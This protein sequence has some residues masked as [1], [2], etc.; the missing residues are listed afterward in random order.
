MNLTQPKAD[1]FV[2]DGLPIGEALA[3]TTHLG[4]GAHQDDLEFMSLHGILECYDRDDRWYSGVVVTNGGGSAR[5][6][7]FAEY[8]DEEMQ[9]VRVQEQC[10]A[11][12]LGRYGSQIQLMFSSAEVKDA[13]YPG[14][15]E[16]LRT[17]VELARPEVVYMHN[18]ADKHDTHVACCLR[19]IAA[20]R[21]LPADLRPA[22]V[23]GCEVWRDLDWLVDA[24]KQA[25][26]LE[27]PDELGPRLARLFESQIAGGKRYDLAVQGRQL[28]NATF[29]QSHEVDQHRALSFAMDLTPLVADPELDIIDFALDHLHRT[30][31]DVADRIRRIS[32]KR[33]GIAS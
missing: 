28:A 22:R 18:P 8:T 31:E 25:L 14:P 16:D 11:A 24:D 20:L 27:D 10:E 15:F 12:A 17:I 29:H 3:R 32:P 5:T 4:V 9:Q 33:K 19:T 26:P 7:L 2:P 1:V 13:S 21:S 30:S 6:G 23:F